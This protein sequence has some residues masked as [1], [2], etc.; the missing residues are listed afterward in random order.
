MTP[1]S[2]RATRATPGL[3]RRTAGRRGAV[4]AS[5]TGRLG[6]VAACVALALAAS[7]CDGNGGTGPDGLRFGQIG[8][9]RL[10]LETPLLLGS[11]AI[12][13]ELVWSSR[14]PWRLVET[15]S[16][17]GDFGESNVVSESRN[18]ETL[19]GEY[20]IWITQINQSNDLRLFIDELDQDLDPVCGLGRTELTLTIRDDVRDETASWNRCVDS[21]LGSFSTR[22]AGPEPVAA[23]VAQ[24][25]ILLRQATVGEGFTSVYQGSFPFATIAKGEDTEADLPRSRTVTDA[26]EWAAFWA[27]HTGTSAEPPAVDFEKDVVLVAAVGVRQEAGDS[28]EVRAVLPVDGRSFVQIVE[29]VPGDFCS[30]VARTHTPFHIVRAP[31]IPLPVQYIELEPELAPCGI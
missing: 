19:A 5:A 7:A 18:P 2:Q 12:E 14:G 4:R 28:V 29:R 31:R 8:E 16:Y 22:S 15:I 10:H 1:P 30:P 13:Q 11:G 6:A 21:S 3:R 17:E 25:G 23:R 27:A 20:A 9:V 26:A 24:A